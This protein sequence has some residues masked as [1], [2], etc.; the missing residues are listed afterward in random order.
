MRSVLFA[1]SLL[2][3]LPIAVHAQMSV[4]IGINLPAYPQLIPVPGYP[5]YYA[6]RAP[7]NYFFYDG[8]YWVYEGDEWYE[9][10]WY[11]GPW[12]V[13]GPEEVPLFVLR[14]P[15][16]YYRKPP[17][18]FRGWNGNAPPR[19]GEHWGPNWEARRGGW[20]QWDHR[21]AP[22]PAPLPDYQRRYSGERYPRALEQQNL[23]RSEHYRY[24]PRESETQRRFGEPG[25]SGTSRAAPRPPAREPREVQNQREGG[26]A[27]QQRDSAAPQPPSAQPIQRP[28]IPPS[29]DAMPQ[30]PQPHGNAG[31][32][33]TETRQEGTGRQRLP[34]QQY[35]R[36][37]APQQPVRPQIR[38]P[39]QPMPA[40]QSTHDPRADSRP[41]RTDGREP[42]GDR[43]RDGRGQNDR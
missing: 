11:N 25:Q 6:P 10:N 26:F 1:L 18:Y 21:S 14:I 19:W 5:V 17:W 9:S 36:P 29:H 37:D 4:S 24:Q 42:D 7:T 13:V 15:V 40:P 23:I 43:R 28:Q 2:L 41:T 3:C 34:E 30:R 8:L 20:D 39:V 35:M 12:Q 38:Q 33:R 16:R 31:S 22:S 27:R 32:S